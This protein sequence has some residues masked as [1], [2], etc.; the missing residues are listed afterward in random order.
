MVMRKGKAKE[1]GIELFRCNIKGRMLWNIRLWQGKEEN[2]EN[3][4]ADA[5]GKLAI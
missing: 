3:L 5:E 2:E 1:S 4:E